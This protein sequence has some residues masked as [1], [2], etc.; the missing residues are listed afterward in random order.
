MEFINDKDGNIFELRDST[1]N[2]IRDGHR[3]A[4]PVEFVKEVLASLDA[5]IESNWEEG[6]ILYYKKRRRSSY[7]LVVVNMPQNLIKTAYLERRM[8]EGKIIWLNP[9]MVR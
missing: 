8:K 5:I 1:I 7:K 6:T 3:I 4:N 9:K 2:H